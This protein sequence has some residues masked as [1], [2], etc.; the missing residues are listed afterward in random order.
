MVILCI[1]RLFGILCGHLVYF[2]VIWYIIP[3]LVCCTKINLA[4]L[5]TVSRVTPPTVSE[6]AAALTNNNDQFQ[7]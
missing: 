5:D 1:L 3:V 2:R 6:R 4:T 7:A